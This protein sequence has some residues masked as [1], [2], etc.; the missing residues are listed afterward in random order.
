[1]IN[2]HNVKNVILDLGG[3]LVDIDPKETDIAMKRILSPEGIESIRCDKVPEMLFD[4]ETGKIKRHEFLDHIRK[5]CKPA[6]LDEEIE[7]AWCA[8][9]L[10]F[11]HERVDMVKAL[12]EKYQIFLLSNTNS[13]HI[14]YFE[15]EFKNRYHFSIQKLFTKV[16]YSSEIGFRKP[17]AECFLHILN[18]AGIKAEETLMID[19][20]EDNCKAA[21]LLG[22]QSLRVPENSGLEAVIDELR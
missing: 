18:D 17:D 3:V 13:L 16:Y 19:D 20:R 4:L 14:K 10:D 22:M 21:E 8:M 7:D 9:I 2:Q 5:Y 6:V 11:P 15:K 1:M 12:S